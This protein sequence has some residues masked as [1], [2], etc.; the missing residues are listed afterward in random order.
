MLSMKI[1]I[2]CFLLCLSLYSG[3]SQN[4]NKDIY[5]P[6]EQVIHPD[7]ENS[8]NK[9]ACL[10]RIISNEFLSIAHKAI[11]QNKIEED[12]LNVSVVF[13]VDKKGKLQDGRDYTFVNDSIL[14]NDFERDLKSITKRFPRF[15]VLNRKPRPYKSNHKLRYSFL[16][17]K[18]NDSI[19]LTPLNE[20]ENVY[21]GGV[22]EEVPQF[23][24]C[25]RGDDKK[26]RECF[27]QNMQ[28]HISKNFR[29]PK[30]AQARGLQGRVNIMFYIDQNGN[31]ANMRVRGPH[32][33]LE[34][35]TV[36]IISLLPKFGPGLENGKPI[37]TPFAIP[38]TF[39]LQ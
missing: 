21:S 23:K 7:C 27:Q 37:R 4:L 5:F 31:V 33:L 10:R 25:K 6:Q 18:S 29:Y 17:E 9:N 34:E 12:T 8:Q 13:E 30:E 20:D 38:I 32:R 11:K 28:K 1:Y 26:A 16:V 14:Q 39:K 15:K 35:E 3:F 19:S 36:R 2:C 24:G 22:I